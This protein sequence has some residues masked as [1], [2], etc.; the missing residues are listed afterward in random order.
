M[1]QRIAPTQSSV[2]KP[3]NSC[4]QNFT[5]SGVVFGGV[6]ALGPSRSSTRFAVSGVKP[7]THSATDG[8]MWEQQTLHAQRD[9]WGQMGTTNHTGTARQMGTTNPTGTAG[10]MGTDGDNKP[11]RHN[12]TDGDRWG[13][14]TLHAQ[15]DRWGQIETNTAGCGWTGGT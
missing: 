7:Y 12:G 4:L 14:Q 13:Q 1:K 8:D 11:Y 2:E 3:P 9:R 5:H 10:Q 15:R 6:S